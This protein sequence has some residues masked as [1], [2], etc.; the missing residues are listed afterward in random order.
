MRGTE[1][2]VTPP[3]KGVPSKPCLEKM[4]L[5]S[6]VTPGILSQLSLSKGSCLKTTLIL[7]SIFFKAQEKS[8][9]T[10]HLL[11]EFNK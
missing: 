4:P 10:V 3:K 8:L 11:N 7:S 2:V 5:L 9:A 1:A 6:L